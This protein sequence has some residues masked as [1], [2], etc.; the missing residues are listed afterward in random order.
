M[1]VEPDETT[2]EV[3]RLQ[4]KEAAARLLD[5]RDATLAARDA[6]YTVAQVVTWLRSGHGRLRDRAM[7]AAAA[8]LI[9][10]AYDLADV[11]VY[12]TDPTPT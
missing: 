2:D 7:H 12:E 9:E 6:E 1:T 8:E 3:S 10:R 11:S 5:L 4:R